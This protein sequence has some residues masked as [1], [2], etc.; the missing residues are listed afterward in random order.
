MVEKFKEWVEYGFVDFD[1]SQDEFKIKIDMKANDVVLETDKLNLYQKLSEDYKSLL[2]RNSLSII[3]KHIHS[4]YKLGTTSR[5]NFYKGYEIGIKIS[6]FGNKYKNHN[7]EFIESVDYAIL[8]VKKFIESDKPFEKYTFRIAKLYDIK[9][10]DFIT[11]YIFNTQDE[12]EFL[13][14]QSRLKI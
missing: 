9:Y 5:K 10:K 12:Y 2:K 13:P 14:V 3:F 1:S 6:G 11:I 4:E 7:Q 8:K